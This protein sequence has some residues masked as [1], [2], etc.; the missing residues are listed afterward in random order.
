MSKKKKSN[1]P[2]KAEIPSPQFKLKDPQHVQH[3]LSQA[4]TFMNANLRHD[5]QAVLKLIATETIAIEDLSKQLRRLTFP[6]LETRSF[7]KPG[8]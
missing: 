8:L 5:T 1:K 4:R 6:D 2:T 7:L 3:W